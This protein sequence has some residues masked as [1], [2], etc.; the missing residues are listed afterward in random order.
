MVRKHYLKF[1]TLLLV[2]TDFIV[3]IF[4]FLL[5]YYIYHQV[6]IELFGLRTTSQPLHI[7]FKLSIVFAISLIIIFERLGL[8]KKHMSILNI[9]ETRKIIKGIALCTFLFIMGI[10]FLK[11]TFYISRLITIYSV[12]IMW[13]LLNS[14]RFLFFKLQQYLHLKGIGVKNTLI[15]GAGEE[16]S[17]L[18]KRLVG[19]PRLGYLPVGFID[20]DICGKDKQIN[21][22]T[23]AN[24]KNLLIFG[25]LDSLEKMVK[26][27][28][29]EEIF[30]AMPS[31]RSMKI[32]RII[33]KCKELN[34][35]YNVIPN[36]YGLNIQKVTYKMIDN[37][38]LLTVKN[39]KIN[40]T[41]IVLKRFFDILFSIFALIIFSPLILIISI[42]IKI[43][44]KGPIVFKQ[45]R[46]GKDGNL[47]LMCKFRT[48]YEDTPKYA[49][50]PKNT[51]DPRIT[52]I[53]KILRRTSLDELPQ[54]WSVL[55]GDMSI[56]G[57]RPEMAFIVESYNDLQ[58]ERLKV[59]PGITGLWQ[60]SGDRGGEIHD[61]INYDLYYIEN[62]SILLDFIV[63]LR[64]V[65][66]VIRGV[67]A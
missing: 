29:I 47:F 19:S 55:K 4:S 51:D 16:G 56:V 66:V 36:L 65:G 41:M 27:N 2:L 12:F 10:F 49:Y 35:K 25:G 22:A 8:Y 37:I 24:P 23:V 52:E 7:Y 50:G 14:E 17:L 57:P 31:A 6:E 48:M 40:Y 42:L 54:F 26:E 38:P 20:D 53:G 32:N 3:I 67:G 60:I 34:I 63:I 9:E 39:H 28:K 58:R 62:M 21:V 64:S 33:R 45:K 44:S 61:D 30:I 43:S 11:I 5:G 1:I 15:Y 59:K 18:A 13:I 46:V